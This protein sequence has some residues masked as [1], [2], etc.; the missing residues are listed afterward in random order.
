MDFSHF[1]EYLKESINQYESALKEAE[2]GKFC[3]HIDCDFCNLQSDINAAELQELIFNAIG[4][5]ASVSS[6]M[7]CNKNCK[8]FFYSVSHIEKEQSFH[9]LA[10]SDSIHFSACSFVS[11]NIK[12]SKSSVAVLSYPTV[13]CSG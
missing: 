6:V 5:K 3:S 10:C 12:E 9:S 11:K 1:P 13:N 2:S 8:Y 4:L 7:Q